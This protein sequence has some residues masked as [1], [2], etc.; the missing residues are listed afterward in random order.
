MSQ[1]F[2][3]LQRAETE[4][5][6]VDMP[7]SPSVAELVQR[8]ELRV[9]SEKQSSVLLEEFPKLASNG[10]S[11]QSGMEGAGADIAAGGVG[12]STV[13][14]HSREDLKSFGQFD[15]LM[16]SAVPDSRLVC[17]LDKESPGAEAF[18]LL[19][20]RLRHLRRDRPLKRVL[21]TSTVPEEGKSVAA[22]N[23]ACSVAAGAGQRTLLLDGD[24]RKP[25]LST[26]FGLEPTLGIYDWLQD[27]C[28]LASS[29]YSLDPAGIWFMPAGN[30]QNNPLE[31]IQSPKLTTLMDTLT[32]AFDWI[33]ID[34]PPVLPFADTSVWA[35][36]ADGI[37]LVTRQ[38]TTE[39][40]K[41]ERGLEAFETNKWIGT[42]LN[43]SGGPLHNRDYYYYRK[44]PSSS[45]S[46]E[47]PSE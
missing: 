41:L 14:M 2:D 24:L 38:G 8:A 34:S 27:K 28:P 9:E 43:C 10:D 46:D 31:L 45:R 37:L 17:L 29:I 19:G 36:L 26:M 7:A 33:I 16:V 21:I 39:K 30:T 35:R 1:I 22:A 47:R 23:L 11:L 42:I 25:S 40:H 15:T 20:V 4:R 3:A 5:S 18:R 6:G 32:A 12:I 44:S 13:A